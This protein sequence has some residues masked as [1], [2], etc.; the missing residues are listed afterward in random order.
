M[1]SEMGPWVQPLPEGSGG[2]VALTTNSLVGARKEIKQGR[3]RDGCDNI[4][5]L[6]LEE[7]LNMYGAVDAF[8]VLGFGEDRR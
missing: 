7:L 4:T 3:E 8:Y 2:T 6:M 1:S 5:F